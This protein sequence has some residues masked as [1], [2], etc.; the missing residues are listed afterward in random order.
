MDKN[1]I[2]PNKVNF[3]FLDKEAEFPQPAYLLSEIPSGKDSGPA[4]IQEWK[5]TTKWIPGC[6]IKLSNYSQ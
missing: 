4:G 2:P 5:T 3:L 6:L 1:P